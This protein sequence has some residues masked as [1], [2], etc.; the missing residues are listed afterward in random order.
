MKQSTHALSAMAI[1]ALVCGQA[2]AFESVVLRCNMDHPGGDKEQV[3][4]SLSPSGQITGFT[5]LYTRRNGGSCDIR[6]DTFQVARHDLMI[7]RNGCQLMAWR[8]GTAVTLA[9][10]PATPQCHSYCTSQ[11]GYEALLPVSFDT[12]GTGCAR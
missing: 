12:R 7:G 2:L 4:M 9:L 10:S 1:A 5:W 3:V 8:Q 6:A 11:R